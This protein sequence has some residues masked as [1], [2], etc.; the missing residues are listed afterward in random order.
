M[1]LAVRQN[2]NLAFT[3]R[4]QK[5]W[6]L[7]YHYLCDIVKKKLLQAGYC[8]IQVEIFSLEIYAA[9]TAILDSESVQELN[10]NLLSSFLT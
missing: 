9:C 7:L 8:G 1:M 6:E 5:T 3:T 10:K 4:K 2:A